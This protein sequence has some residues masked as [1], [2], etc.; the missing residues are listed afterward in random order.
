MPF[1]VQ[2]K[3]VL[4]T[5][6]GREDI[7]NNEGHLLFDD[8]IVKP[9]H[10]SNLL[11]ALANTLFANPTQKRNKKSKSKTDN[12]SNLSVDEIKS[13]TKRFKHARI[14]LVEDNEINRDVAVGLFQERNLSIELAENGL[15]A[16]FRVKSEPWDLVFMDMHMPI[17]DGLK[18]V[19]ILKEEME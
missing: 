4:A 1:V 10:G 15:E 14:L 13:F 9:V 19:S 3:L 6:L 11:D 18:T 12:S 2:P 5:A 17:M 16:L 7:R 8:A